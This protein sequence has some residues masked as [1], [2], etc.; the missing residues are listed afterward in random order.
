MSLIPTDT[1]THNTLVIA[2]TG[3]LYIGAYFNS[4]DGTSWSKG[5][6]NECPCYKLLPKSEYN[7]L[8]QTFIKK[9]WQISTFQFEGWYSMLNRETV[10]ARKRFGQI[11]YYQV[12]QNVRGYD[13]LHAFIDLAIKD[14]DLI[15]IDGYQ[16]LIDI[17][18]RESIKYDGKENLKFIEQLFKSGIALKSDELCNNILNYG[19]TFLIEGKYEEA[20]KIYKYNDL[21]YTLKSYGLSIRQIITQDLSEFE[22]KGLISKKVT[23][24]IIKNINM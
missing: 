5:N 16:G 8:N 1:Q 18:D 6:P 17:L 12:H 14:L 21:D 3:E 19:H 23:E 15:K 10:N 9:Y 7:K 11:I 4:Y 2:K 22:L 13:T 20:L 24:L